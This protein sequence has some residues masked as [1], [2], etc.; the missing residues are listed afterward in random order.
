MAKPRTSAVPPPGSLAAFELKSLRMEFSAVHQ[1]WVATADRR[2]AAELFARLSELLVEMNR[3][4]EVI[5]RRNALCVVRT[6]RVDAYGA[7]QVP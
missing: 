5:R 1:E 2:R 6:F 3:V 7:P 4:A